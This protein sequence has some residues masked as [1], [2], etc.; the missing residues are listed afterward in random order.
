[1]LEQQYTGPI[2]PD[3][4]VGRQA[5]HDTAGAVAGYELLFRSGP[6]ALRADRNGAVRWATGTVRR[7]GD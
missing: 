6:E 7:I 2:A 3:V 5:I 1:M 4:V